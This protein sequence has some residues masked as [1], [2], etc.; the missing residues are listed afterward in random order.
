MT[1][2]HSV[3]P[4]RSAPPIPVDKKAVREELA[5][6]KS[7][8][9]PRRPNLNMKGPRPPPKSAAPRVPLMSQLALP[10]MQPSPALDLPK[11]KVGDPSKKIA[12]PPRLQPQKP[13]P[14]K[15][16]HPDEME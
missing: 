6:A 5:Q 3:T 13:R 2:I 8:F 15:E 16:P 10:V 9:Q 1:R 7:L 12:P 11:L 4:P 14:P